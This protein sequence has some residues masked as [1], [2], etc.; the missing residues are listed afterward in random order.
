MVL[1]VQK[2]GARIGPELNFGGRVV[3]PEVSGFESWAPSVVPY[4]GAAPFVP[5]AMTAA[6]IHHV[7]KCFGDA[8]R[9]AVEAGCDFVGIHG[10]H[11]YLIS[12]FFSPY[13]NKRDDEYGGDLQRRMRFP[14]RDRGGGARGDRPRPADPLSPQRRRAPARRRHHAAGCLRAGAAARGRRRRSDRRLGRHVRDELVDHAADGDA[15]GRAVEVGAAG[16]PGSRHPRQRLGP[17]HGPERGRACDRIGLLR[18]RDPGP[19]DAR[20]PRVRQQGARR[21][22]GR[23]L[24]LHRLQPGLQ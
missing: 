17:D 21:P 23:D 19:G 20:R 16:A 24:H 11:G 8:A 6:D 2:H 15:A 18:L 9:R 7:V 1:A 22:A 12:Q 14:L 13:A 3:H 5:H 10:A 4:V